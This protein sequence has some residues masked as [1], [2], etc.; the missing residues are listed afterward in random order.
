MLSSLSTTSSRSSTVI[1]VFDSTACV[2][3]Y[4]LRMTSSRD[5]KDCTF[6]MNPNAIVDVSYWASTQNLR[7]TGRT[8][9]VV[10]ADESVVL[11]CF[12]LATT[13]RLY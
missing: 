2:S 8:A 3:K 6:S 13:V 5:S 9:S 7:S 12:A 10:T 1:V 4:F 11:S